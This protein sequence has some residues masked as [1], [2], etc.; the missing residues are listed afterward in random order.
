MPQGW[1]CPRRAPRWLGTCTG[2]TGWGPAATRGWLWSVVVVVVVGGRGRGGSAP[3]CTPAER[4][5]TSS[6]SSPGG[7]WRVFF[8]KNADGH[9]GAHHTHMDMHPTELAGCRWPRWASRRGTSARCSPWT[10]ARTAVSKGDVDKRRHRCRAVPIQ[11]SRTDH[12]ITRSHRHRVPRRRA[13]L[14]R[15][16]RVGHEP[17]VPAHDHLPPSA[18]HTRRARHGGRPRAALGSPRLPAVGGAQ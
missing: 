5:G 14:E 2:T 3:C 9:V 10:S 6:W 12:H 4:Q 15:A 11:P 8:F 7:K 17:V 16:Q 13:R 1:G 18:R